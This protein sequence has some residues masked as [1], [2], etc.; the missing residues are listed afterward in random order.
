MSTYT[1]HL[2]IGDEAHDETVEA[3]SYSQ[4]I[5]EVWRRFGIGV[6]IKGHTLDEA[7]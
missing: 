4:A 3:E 7:D 6:Y 5:E 1:M 2:L